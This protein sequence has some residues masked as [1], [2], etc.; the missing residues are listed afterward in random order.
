MESEYRRDS[1]RKMRIM[2]VLIAVTATASLFSLFVCRLEGIGLNDA[3]EVLAFHLFGIGTPDQTSDTVIW[4]YNVPRTLLGI[5]TGASLAIGGAVMQTILRNPL[6][7]P[8]TTGVS[9]GASMGAA[10]FIY[11]DFSILGTGLGYYQTIAANAIVFAMLPTAAILM[12][13]AYRHVTP[14][15]MILAGIAL[16]YV[17]TASTSILMLMADPDNV[18][19]TYEWSIGS[20]ARGS[21]NNI[22]LVA[23]GVAPCMLVLGL[24]SRQIGV[25]NA[26]AAGAKGMGVNVKAVRNCA[27]LVIAA[28]TSVTVGVT[29]GI[30]FMGLVAPHV[31]RILV[32][33]DMRY[34]LPCSAILGAL[35]LLCADIVSRSIVSASI[36]VGVL[37]AI[38]GGPVFI[39]ILIKGS[40]KI[41]F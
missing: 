14:T 33:S 41:W 40:R 20:L 39:A 16:M 17:F 3:A 38:I 18:Q 15:T 32:G 6:A 11:L 22:G 1:S 36:P 12:V 26:G 21:W 9:A 28:M 27:L 24:L 31:A 7:T 23:L 5:L 25:M 34:L 29:G 30:G 4:E 37:T 2:A 13:S 10:L 19:E 8:Y 35:I